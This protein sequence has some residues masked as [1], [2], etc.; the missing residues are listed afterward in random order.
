MEIAAA[1]AGVLLGL[2]A[3]LVAMRVRRGLAAQ[4]G[5][6]WRVRFRS[7]QAGPINLVLYAVLRY[8][9]MQLGW[10][11]TVSLWGLSVA[12]GPLFYLYSL[13]NIDWTARKFHGVGS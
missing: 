8:V 7:V 2:V 11:D 13:Q 3:V 6:E 12:Y 4:L 5:R 10:N 1:I 9:T